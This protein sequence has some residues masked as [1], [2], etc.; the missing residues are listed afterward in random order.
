M[1]YFSC[2]W[3]KIS[4]IVIVVIALFCVGSI[5][6]EEVKADEGVDLRYKWECKHNLYDSK[7]Y[8]YLGYLRVYFDETQGY[9]PGVYLY[10]SFYDWTVK[11]NY[12]FS[13]YM[14]NALLLQGMCSNYP[15]NPVGSSYQYVVIPPEYFKELNRQ[16]V[17]TI[18]TMSP[19][20]QIGD[21]TVNNIT[22]YKPLIKNNT[23]VSAKQ[24]RG[25]QS[26]KL[27]WGEITGAKNYSVYRSKSL[28]GK[29]KKIGETTSTNIFDNNVKSGN[30][31]YYYVEAKY[32]DYDILATNK[33][34]VE[35]KKP[36]L[37]I[38]KIKVKKKRKTLNIY[39]GI[40]PDSSKGIEIY[41]KEGKNKKYKKVNTTTNLKK[42]KNK[43]GAVGITA[44]KK[45]LK[46]GKK[47]SFRARTYTYFNNEKIYGRWSKTVSIKG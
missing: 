14:D 47:Y 45:Y 46:K 19:S 23:T 31:Y 2:L 11:S 21:V 12:S 32:V 1:E 28:K 15:Y 40:I 38:P 16:H 26:V 42:N 29:Y 44:S 17:I 34:S 9:E 20:G 41:M 22:L 6:P 13:V 24:I 3:K 4:R 35:V 39:W 10:L 25:K 30:K 7:S 37:S 18:Y 33:T 8:T 43:K 36:E 5:M 27:E